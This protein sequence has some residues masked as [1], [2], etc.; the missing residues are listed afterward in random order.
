MFI[1]K[2]LYIRKKLCLY[3]RGCAFPTIHGVPPPFVAVSLVRVPLFLDATSKFVTVTEY[4][5]FWCSASHHPSSSLCA[6]CC[7]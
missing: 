3:K 4:H 6:N 5:M 7:L 1:K 2:D